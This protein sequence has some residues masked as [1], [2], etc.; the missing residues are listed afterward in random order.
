MDISNI[1][2]DSGPLEIVLV[3]VAS[4]DI[5][6][7]ITNYINNFF[8]IK[9]FFARDDP[10]VKQKSIYRKESLKKRI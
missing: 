5:I 1:I 3:W 2:L 8:S 10:S 6:F 4:P 9:N 7:Y